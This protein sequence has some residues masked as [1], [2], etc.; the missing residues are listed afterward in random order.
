MN[1]RFDIVDVATYVCP[2]TVDLVFSDVDLNSGERSCE[3]GDILPAPACSDLIRTA[4]T[5]LVV[6]ASCESFELN[7]ELISVSNVVATHDMISVEMFASW[8]ENLYS[9]LSSKPLSEAFDYAVKASRA[10]MKLYTKQ[11]FIVPHRE[12]VTMAAEPVQ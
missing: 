4:Q 9:A 12:A 8:I 1:G 7:A 2:K 5:K 6:I 10:P 11:N 3:P